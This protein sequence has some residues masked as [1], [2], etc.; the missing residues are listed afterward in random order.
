MHHINPSRLLKLALIVDA[1]IS[2]ASGVLQITAPQQLGA[3]LQLPQALLSATGNFYLVYAAALILL[4]TRRRL[5][6]GL[7]LAIVF[8]NLAWGLAGAGALLT[9]SLAPNLLGV[10]FVLMQVAAVTAFAI[11]QWFGLR[12][13]APARDAP[14]GD[15]A[16]HRRAG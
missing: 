3:V 5:W 6:V 11:A 15:L 7:V 14:G 1:V 13:S 8:G 16:A 12:R 9:G 10:A 4:A 2:G